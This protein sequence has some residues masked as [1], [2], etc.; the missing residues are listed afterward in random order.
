MTSLLSKKTVLITGAAS[1]IGLAMS[2]NFAEQG[3]RLILVDVNASALKQEAKALQN[4]FPT[5]EIEAIKV[6]I[7][8][9]KEVEKKLGA[10]KRVDILVN[11][12]GIGPGAEP[13]Y[14]SKLENDEATVNVNINGTMYV[15][16]TLLPGMVKRKAGHV[17]FIGSIAAVEP[18][19]NHAMYCATKAATRAFSQS[20]RREL[21]DKGVKIS[22]I[23]PGKVRT[24]FSLAKYKGNTKKA[25]QEYRAFAPLEAEDIANTAVFI[26][27][28]PAH[29]QIQEVVMTS[30]DQAMARLVKNA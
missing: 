20:L 21:V 18:Y 15:T 22:I 1:G 19:D 4:L 23:H 27:S 3:A 29:V 30:S 16:R 5:A 28:Q 2:R 7:C 26:A 8:K 25:Q 14:K 11:N 10:I 24:N 17:I 6:D 9:R 13:F 12:A